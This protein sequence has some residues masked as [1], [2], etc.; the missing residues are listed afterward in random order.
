[1]IYKNRAILP[2]LK[3][4]HGVKESLYKISYVKSTMVLRKSQVVI[5]SSSGA[6]LIEPGHRWRLHTSAIDN[7]LNI[8]LHEKITQKGTL[9]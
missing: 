7:I 8:F 5:F 6:S 2:P 3:Q 1:M 9:L 4:E